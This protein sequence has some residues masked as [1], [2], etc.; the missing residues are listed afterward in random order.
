MTE[1]SPNDLEV[2]P[3]SPEYDALMMERVDKQ[4]TQAPTQTDRPAWLPEKF[5]TPEDL[6]K[7]YSELERKQSTGKAPDAAPPPS[8]DEV[9]KTVENA[10]LDFDA[11]SNEFQENGTLSDESYEA[12]TKAGF[13][14]EYV[15]AYIEGQKAVAAQY[16]SQIYS[17]VGGEQ[18]YADMVE[19][20]G[21]NLSSAEV[22]AF[23][24]A[25]GSG[26]LAHVALAVKGLRA[27]YE[28]DNGAEPKLV[29]ADNS[30]ATGEVYRSTAELT[31]A[32]RDPRYKNDPAYRS[33]VE[34]KLKNSNIF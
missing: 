5:Q 32:M 16:A 29:T 11:L 20:A 1:V 15:D 14:K 7:A 9:Q 17:L 33:D 3:G 34:R 21:S 28:G 12:L 26:D 4:T 25:I 18:Q 19:W 13:P 10:G 8:P 22:E 2:T 24:A 30:R 23:N 31:A 27:S 6:A